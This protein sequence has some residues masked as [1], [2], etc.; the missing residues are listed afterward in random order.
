MLLRIVLGFGVAFRVVEFARFTTAAGVFLI[1]IVL[2][3]LGAFLTTLSAFFAAALSLF[4]ARAFSAT[5]RAFGTTRF[6]FLLLIG[7][8][9]ALRHRDREG[10]QQEG[11]QHNDYRALSGF[12]FVLLFK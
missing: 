1:C 12:H 8:R 6:G 9:R 3:A 2:A 10:S 7:L 4:F 5:V 11:E